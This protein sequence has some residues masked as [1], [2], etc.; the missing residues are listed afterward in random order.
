MCGVEGRRLGFGEP[1]AR[2]GATRR[3]IKR[4]IAVETAKIMAL[5]LDV[6][7]ALAVGFARGL[8]PVVAGVQ[9]ADPALYGVIASILVATAL[10]G[11]W[12][13]ARRAAWLDA[14]R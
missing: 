6:G 2:R 11:A 9:S 7:L 4:L 14:V 8:E 10:A 12:V 5:R 13:P 3:D 1:P